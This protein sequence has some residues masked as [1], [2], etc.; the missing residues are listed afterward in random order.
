[1]IKAI[2]SALTLTLIPAIAS[3]DNI[4]GRASVVDG[5]TIEINGVRIRFEGIDA[6]ESRQLCEDAG[7]KRYRCG[8]VS[9]KALDTFLSQS[10]PTTCTA[11]GKSYDRIVGHCVR[12]DG[13]NVNAWMVRNGH[14]IDWPKY[15]NG[16]YA[17]DQAEAQAARLGI[18][19][20][21]FEMPCIAR[22]A[23]CD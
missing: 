3:A 13:L 18:W 8:Q 10:R 21:K 9:A 1:M 14:A 7:G 12:S 16:R 23:R 6:P 5:D 2:V 19:G 15:S 22:G 20:G 11:T 17:E 4:T